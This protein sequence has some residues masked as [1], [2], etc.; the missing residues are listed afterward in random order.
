MHNFYE[1]FYSARLVLITLMVIKKSI[2]MTTGP[3]YL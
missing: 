1:Y 2:R 3:D